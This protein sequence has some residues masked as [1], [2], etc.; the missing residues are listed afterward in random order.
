MNFGRKKLII[1]LIIGTIV[2]VFSY[3]IGAYVFKTESFA[4]SI[5]PILD[6]SVHH[7]LQNFV[8]DATD[9][10]LSAVADG[11]KKEY[12]VLD[13]VCAYKR[14]DH[15]LHI[16]CQSK[17]PVWAIQDQVLVADGD[18]IPKSSFVA[19]VLHEIPIIT[20]HKK[21]AL[22]TMSGYLKQWLLALDKKIIDAYAITVLD[23]YEIYLMEKQSKNQ[24]ICN[25]YTPINEKIRENCHRIIDEKNMQAQ[26]T[27]S[28]YSYTV[29]IRFEKQIIICS[30]KGGAVHG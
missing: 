25:I 6:R 14:A 23:D 28:A 7:A 21:N 4:F 11:L 27:A 12:P 5:D 30:Q 15:V 10:S 20:L 22:T 24:L 8:T 9:R 16:A 13:H 17:K 2:G 18:L 26:G 29:D 3:K 1:I 19:S